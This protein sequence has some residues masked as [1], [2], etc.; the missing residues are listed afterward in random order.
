MFLSNLSIA[1]PVF[2]TVLMLSLVTLGIASYRRLAIDLYP[3]VEIPVI[4][5]VTV[6]PGASPEAVEREVSKPVEE[7]VHPIAG[8][9]HVGSTS[10]ESVSQIVVEFQLEVKAD[11]AIQDARTKI[12]A[13]RGDLPAGVQDPIIEKLDVAVLP[14]VSLA[15][16]SSVLSPRDLTTLVDRK[17]KPRLENVAGVG[18]ID[19]VGAVTREIWVEVKP[20]RLDALAVGIDEVIGGLRRENIDTPLGRLSRAASESPL[21]VQGKAKTV[22]EFRTMVV[23]SRGGRSIALG[24]VADVSDGVEEVRSLAFVDAV[25]AVAL[26]VLKQTGANAVGVADAIKKEAK[27]LASELPTGT[28]VEIVRDGSVMIR[29]SVEDVQQ[30][31]VIGGLLTIL[32]VFI[33]LNSWRSTVITGLTLPIS[34]ISSF[35]VMNF[36]GMTLNVMTLMALSLAIGLLIDDAIVVRENVVRPLEHG[37]DHFEAARQGTS[38]IGLAVLATTFSIIA[39]FVPVAFMKGVVCRFFFAFG[40][41]VAFAVLVSLFVSFTLDPMLSSRWID[42]DIARTGRRNPISRALD[43]FNGWFDRTADGYKTV[44]AWA[45]RHRLA[46]VGLAATAFAGG[47]TVMGVLESEFF[48]QFDQGEFAVSFKAAPDASIEETRDRL[49]VVT[50]AIRQ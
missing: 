27:A 34:V 42:P 16:R 19:L 38:E 17:I 14:L 32:I 4:T 7:A 6:Y 37:E 18:K 24:E 44:I 30:T 31:L 35:I 25:P 15:V 50:T 23:T 20:D 22:D 8:V 3:N 46:V 12:A 43:W 36:A 29:E 11:Q 1:R 47:L 48:P 41:T 13:I 33:F 28:T 39:V 45:L 5:I 9:R 21:R 49:N 2:A 40:I 10:R 26:D